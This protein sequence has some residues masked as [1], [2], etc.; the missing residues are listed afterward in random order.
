MK[1]ILQCII[2]HGKNKKITRDEPI[3]EERGKSTVCI[4]IYKIK[5]YW[6][7]KSE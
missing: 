4:T 7:K 5:V 3:S 6:L 1:I 2:E